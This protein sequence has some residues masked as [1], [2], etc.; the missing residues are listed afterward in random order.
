MAETKNSHKDIQNVENSES[1]YDIQFLLHLVWH[2]RYWLILSVVVCLTIAYF[3]L[4]TKTDTYA[5]EMMI[6]IT[7][8]KNAGMSNSAQVS[9]IQ[10]MTGIASFN[11]LENEKVIIR[12][13]PV[14]QKVVEEQKLNIRY[15]VEQT[16]RD[17]E[18]LGQEIRMDYQPA[19]GYNVNNLP[20]IRID[21]EVI[22]TTRMVISIQ[23]T[24]RKRHGSDGYV[25]RDSTIHLPDTLQ[26]MRYGAIAFRYVAPYRDEQM[27][28]EAAPQEEGK[29][30]YVTPGDHYILLYSPQA[31]AHEI[32]N[33][34]TVSV[35]EDG[36][37]SSSSFSGGGSSILSLSLTDII[38]ARAEAALEG[39]VRQYNLQTKEYYSLTHTN[40]MEFIKNR[41]VDLKDQLSGVEGRIKEFSIGNDVYDLQSQTSFNL[42]TDMQ[43]QQRLQEIDIQ[44]SLLGMIA[45]ELREQKESNTIPS[46]VGITD[47]SILTAITEYNRLCVERLRLLNSATESSPVVKDINLQLKTRRD[48]ICKT[49]ENQITL[50]TSQHDEISQQLGRS[51]NEMQRLPSKRLNLAEIEREQSVIEPLY[52]LLQKKREETMLAIIA[53]PDI[54]RVVEYAENNSV[55]IGPNRRKTYLIALILGLAIPLAIGYLI[56]LLKTKITTPDDISTRT[57]IPVI[58]I[59]PEGSKH[60]T[61]AKDIIHDSTTSATA[62]IFRSIRSSI[63]FMEGK[64]V[65]VTSSIPSEGKSFVSVNLA[66]CLASAGK[67]TVLIETDMRK[68]HQRRVFDVPKD[69]RGG[70]S[71]YLSGQTEDWH[72]IIF[73][74][75][76]ADDLDV[77]LKGAVP[78]NPNELLSSTRLEKLIEE[79]KAEYD[80][81]IL[82]S[83]PYLLIADPITINR[84]ADYNIYVMRANVSD[85]RFINEVNMAVTNEKLTKPYIV[86]N[87]VD[88]KAQTY[89][90]HSRYGYGYGYAYG[91]SYGYNDSTPKKSWWEK[92]LKK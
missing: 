47:N 62:E 43:R 31:R 20:L 36:K 83:P 32:G 23:D 57:N 27:S 18:T 29:F 66:L 84:V 65:Q 9:F 50:L 68:G 5:S 78:P 3:N 54:A 46:N 88:M 90:G 16:F 91:Y 87:G 21:Y 4:R 79:L 45:K 44:I 52:V 81:V 25:L 1:Q 70:L 89:Y 11:S 14:I 69:F 67:K 64:V 19:W 28:E 58:G 35:V 74:D 53:E 39:I 76:G 2:L 34:I 42:N 86:L 92:V 72:S 24:S 10:D 12:S 75:T 40:T 22:D 80:Y 8:D 82:D 15:F 85:L 38:P 63:C 49:I 37:H 71:Q 33:A 77:I 17:T 60:V 48:L 51:K 41:L 13:T 59:I 56:L 61:K 7:T 26:L 73:H 6:L 30:Q 55:F